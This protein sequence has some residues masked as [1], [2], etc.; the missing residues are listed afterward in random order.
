MPVEHIPHFLRRAVSFGLGC[1]HWATWVSSC[2]AHQEL[3]LL[4]RIR[5]GA[6]ELHLVVWG[7]GIF[8]TCTFLYLAVSLLG[9]LHSEKPFFYALVFAA[10]MKLA[11]NLSALQCLTLANPTLVWAMASNA[12]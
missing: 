10:A 1:E 5:I 8:A 4:I 3:V 9:V 7:E 6:L 2:T 12:D 11:C